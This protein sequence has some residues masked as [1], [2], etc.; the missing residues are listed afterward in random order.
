MSAYTYRPG[1]GVVFRTLAKNI[2]IQKLAK[3]HFGALWLHSGPLCA[4]SKPAWKIKEQKSSYVL[5]SV[6]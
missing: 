6:S 1:Q 3:S 5:F 4:I 2:K